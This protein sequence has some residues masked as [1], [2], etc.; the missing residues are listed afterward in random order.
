[1]LQRTIILSAALFCYSTVAFSNDSTYIRFILHPGLDSNRL[2]ISI[3]DG[4]QEQR[5][6]L[7]ETHTWRGRLF[8][9]YGHIFVAYPGQDTAG[10]AKRIFFGKGNTIVSVTPGHSVNEPF[11][12]NKKDSKNIFPYEEMGGLELDAYI[13]EKQD[14]QMAFYHRNKRRF[15]ADENLV[16]KMLDMGDTVIFKKLEFIRQ[17]P[18]LYASFWNFLN[19]TYKS[20]VLSPDS[21]L[22]TYN[23]IFPEKYKSSKASEYMV[24]VLNNKIAIATKSHFPEFSVTDINNNIITSESLRG[25]YVLI[26][27]WASW[28]IPCINEMPVIRRIHEQYRQAPFTILSIS[29][30]QNAQAFRTAV[31]KHAMNWTQVHGDLRLYNAMG[32][33]PIPQLYLLDKSGRVIYNNLKG[34]DIELRLLQS[35]LSEK[36]PH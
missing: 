22:A 25:K 13:K 12:I 36:L 5:L 32:Y 1:M 16:Q 14:S 30:D 23:K 19:N 27:F 33:A 35:T 20:N 31:T 3:H 18:G 34:T 7:N 9:P 26:Q 24:S 8:S 2:T 11:C 29:I 21:M 17:H 15:G 10:F 28:C 4:I 6:K